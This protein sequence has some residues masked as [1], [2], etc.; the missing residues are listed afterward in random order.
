L[1]DAGTGTGAYT[2]VREDF[3]APKRYVHVPGLIHAQKACDM[4]F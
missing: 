1:R 3:S 4:L 2:L